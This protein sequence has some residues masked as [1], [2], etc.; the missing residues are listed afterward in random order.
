MNPWAEY[1]PTD[2]NPWDLKK[3][4]HLYR[5]AAF[6]ATMAE[7]E[8]GLSDGPSKTIQRLLQ[9]EAE[10][11]SFE[12]T[13][14]VMGNPRSLPPSAE[15]ARLS[16]WWLW[17]IQNTHH[18][19]REKLTLF[20]HNH[21][22]TSNAKV[23]NAQLMLQHYRTL[24][25]QALGDFRALLH[26]MTFDP[27]MLIWLDA[28]DSRKGQPNENFAREVM[29]LFSLGIGNY[30]EA[31]IREA[32]RALTGY[33]LNKANA[34]VFQAKYHDNGEKTIFGQSGAFRGEDIVRLC[35]EQ[36][37]CAEFICRKLYRLFI[38]ESSEPSDELIAPL[39]ELYRKS[40]YN[41]ASVVETILKSQ[42]FFS[43]AAYRQRVKAPVEFAIGIVRGLEGQP[44]VLPLAEA[45]EQLGQS[46]LAPPSVK[47][48]DGGTA[49]LNAQS[50][51]YRQNLALALTSGSDPAIGKRCDPV[52]LLSQHKLSDVEASI[53]F[54][55][56]LFF[57]GDVLPEYR[58]KLVDY[59][60]ANKQNRSDVQRA[61]TYLILAMPEY[62]LE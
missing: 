52:A 44:G 14:K 50:L 3:V 53:D 21:F 32:S 61:I 45:F 46:L 2:A 22:A 59:W 19:L 43:T 47:G 36:P 17:R 12:Q 37:A 28:K 56:K 10:Q 1:T 20:W 54:L 49:W 60:Q 23:A 55:L 58:Q 16:A 24:Y 26:D 15:Q 4:G 51:L 41:T 29:E 40:Q 8:R 30:T 13:S 57:Q 62:Q 6:G 9:G 48:W 34:L 5:R 38:S 42:H 7:L 31:D 33:G 25:K 35:L 11:P 18:P 39:A 27:A